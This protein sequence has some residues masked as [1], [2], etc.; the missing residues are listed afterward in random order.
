MISAR[1]LASFPT[2]KR[3]GRH[4]AEGESRASVLVTH[5]G[6][7]PPLS[8]EDVRRLVANAV[9]GLKQ[10]QVAVLFVAQDRKPMAALVQTENAVGLTGLRPFAFSLAAILALAGA[11]LVFRRRLAGIGRERGRP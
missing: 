1:V 3:P 5:W 10:E 4:Q 7:T 2:Q 9:E 8:R 11:V 6:K